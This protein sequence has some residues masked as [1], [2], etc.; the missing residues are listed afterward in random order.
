MQGYVHVQCMRERRVLPMTN[1]ENG[2]EVDWILFLLPRK[3]NGE[4]P[5]PKKG[6]VLR[7]GREQF[8]Y[9]LFFPD[10]QQTGDSQRLV[11]AVCC[12]LAIH[13]LIYLMITCI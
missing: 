2:G 4:R 10:S 1:T 3:G 9:V 8:K 6:T 13:A 12:S 5:K 11:G 7:Q